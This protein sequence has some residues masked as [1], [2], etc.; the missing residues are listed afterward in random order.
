VVAQAFNASTQE[1]ET[2]RSEFE[3]NPIY[4]VS[5]RIARAM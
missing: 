4:I 1:A 2:G 3:A 5:S